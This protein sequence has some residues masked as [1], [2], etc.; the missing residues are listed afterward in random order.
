M[1][2]RSI[3]SAAALLLALAGTVF[4][5]YLAVRDVDFDTVWAT[6]ERCQYLWLLPSLLLLA[7]AVYIRAL[8]WGLLF[9]PATRPSQRALLNALLIGYFLNQ[10]LPARAGEAAR[11]VSLH[12][13]AGTS[14]A[15]ALGTAVAERIY[16]VMALLLLLFAAAPFLPAVTW[17]R[18]AGVLAL[19]LLV[20]IVITIVVIERYRERPV[21]FLLRP[22]ARLPGSS[23]DRS[24]AAAANLVHGLG[25]LHRPR[26]ATPVFLV[27]LVSWVVA[28]GSYWFT[29]VAFD[30][31]LGLRAGL[32]IVIATNLA[33]VI[34]SLPA[35]VGVF[36]AATILSLAAYGISRSEALSVAVALHAVNFLPFVVAGLFVLQRHSRVLRRRTRLVT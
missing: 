25:A 10:I 30:L 21:R 16:D 35:A 1:R 27:T 23:V 14:R 24:N 31:G 4:F 3:R 32:L 17:L 11:V 19:V 15:E 13:E 28:A 12:Q 26:A 9:A 7:A 2:R 33:L 8:R 36:E 5:T 22:F 6:L 29:L 20:V 34:P 18:R